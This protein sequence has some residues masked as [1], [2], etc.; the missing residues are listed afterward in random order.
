MGTANHELQASKQYIQDKHKSP[1]LKRWKSSAAPGMEVCSSESVRMCMCL[2]QGVD[3]WASRHTLCQRLLRIRHLPALQLPQCAAP[4]PLHDNRR[5]GCRPTLGL[6][7]LVRVLNLLKRSFDL[8]AILRRVCYL[9]LHMS[10][11]CNT[12]GF[13]NIMSPT[14]HKCNFKRQ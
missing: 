10:V 9:Q 8:F 12:F 11:M 5:Y 14:V 1:L 7:R 6:L 2:V 3:H 13:S 4:S